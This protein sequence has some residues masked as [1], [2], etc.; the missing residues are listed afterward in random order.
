MSDADRTTTSHTASEDISDSDQYI[1]KAE[2]TLYE[3]SRYLENHRALVSPVGPI[4][5][6]A[7]A[8]ARGHKIS[9]RAMI[10]DDCRRWSMQLEDVFAAQG[11]S[12]QTKFAALTTL[13]TEVEAH[14]VRDLTMMGDERPSK[15][16]D[17]ATSLFIKR[18]E[19]IVHQR[20]TRALSMSGLEV[21]ENPTHG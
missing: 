6:S 21:D 4:A 11:I 16:F 9:F 2:D 17:A 8:S 18:Y 7:S 14:V 13:L 10:Y 1:T 19:L 3:I 12:S 5:A 20:L 15:I